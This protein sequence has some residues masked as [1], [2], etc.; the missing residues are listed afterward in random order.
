MGTRQELCIYLA[1]ES[2][3]EQRHTFDVVTDAALNNMGGLFMIDA[4]AETGKSFTQCAIADHIRAQRKLVLCTPS[5]GI[6]ALILPGGL[7]AH[8]RLPFGDKSVEG[9]V[10]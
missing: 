6:A 5:S 10:M 1:A 9:S 8:Y 7:T 2:T 4:P 3:V